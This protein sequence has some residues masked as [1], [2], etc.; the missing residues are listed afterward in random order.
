MKRRNKVLS[1][2]LTVVMLAGMLATFGTTVS[3][4]DP[5]WVNVPSQI[6]KKDAAAFIDS[7]IDDAMAGGRISSVSDRSGALPAGLELYYSVGSTVSPWV[8]GTPTET[9][10]FTYSVNV[11]LDNAKAFTLNFYILVSNASPKERS[12]TIYFDACEAQD[13][14]LLHRGGVFNSVYTD[15]GYYDVDLIEG[16]VPRGMDYSYGEWNEPHVYGTPD[17][18]GEWVATFDIFQYDGNWI[19]DSV[20]FIVQPTQII[21]TSETVIFEAGKNYNYSLQ[22]NSEDQ[23]YD[24]DV[25]YG[26]LPTGMDWSYSE[27]DGPRVYGKPEKAGVWKATFYIADFSGHVYYHKVTFIVEGDNPFKDVEAGKFYMD[28]VQWAVNHEP[29]ITK[30]TDTT[31]FSPNKTCTRAQVVTFLWRA[32]GEPE[33]SIGYNPFSDIEGAAYYYSAVLWA[34]ENGI[35]NGMDADHFGPDVG[36]T[37]GQ[38]VTFMWRALGM[39]E[40]TV[41]SSPF[42]DVKTDA[43]YYK[44][45]LWA[46]ENGVTNGMTATTFEPNTTCTRGQIVT[47][48]CRA[49]VPEPE[50]L[51]VNTL[52]DEFL[53]YVED[54]FLISER[55]T[56]VTGRVTNGKIRTGEKVTVYTWDSDGNVL[57]LEATVL[58][59][60]M[61]HKLL[62]YAE[63]GDNI[64]LWIDNDGSL[65][66]SVERGSAVVKEGSRLKPVKYVTGTVYSDPKSRHTTMS[67]DN[68]FQYYV[69]TTDLAASF[70]TLNGEYNDKRIFPDETRN[71]VVIEF[72]KP[73]MVYQGQEIAIRGGGMTYGTFTVTG[74]PRNLK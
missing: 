72:N 57:P 31:H 35:T 21:T 5:E 53:I 70:V 37:R 46:V 55:G 52:G 66:S 62:D 18:A 69:G 68:I 11:V 60:E 27:V 16:Y 36:C 19:R 17:C 26:A 47:F 64:G 10:Y 41:T 67:E 58:G 3:A 39:P 54:V 38:V 56:V 49:M 15:G 33:P 1:L 71:G 32:L 63:K 30:G 40:P 22:D 43:Y 42:K 12:E 29:V 45:M 61:F 25:D 20:R 50:S 51:P 9:G 74:A 4:A 73:V 28:P 48:L 2:L 7:G 13:E 24:C 14:Y 8:S 65:K 6:V 34:V 23:Y 59:I 44:A